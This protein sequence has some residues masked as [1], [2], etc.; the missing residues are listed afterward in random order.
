MI[1]LSPYIVMFFILM[2]ISGCGAD[3]KVIED[4]AFIQTKGYD[5]IAGEDLEDDG[6]EVMYRLTTSAPLVEPDREKPKISRV[7]TAR[8]NKEGIQLNARTT[9]R[10]IVSGQLRLLLYSK[11]VVENGLRPLLDVLE[12]DP[13][14]PARAKLAIVEGEVNPLMEREFDEHPRTTIYLDELLEKEARFNVIPEIKVYQFL[15]DLKDDGKDPTLPMI[16]LEEEGVAVN[17]LAFLKNDVYKTKLELDDSLIY[18]FLEK[19]VDQGDL[20]MSL[21]NPETGKNELVSFTSISTERDISVEK[22]EESFDVNIEV[23][24][25]GTI[26]ENIGDIDI[27]DEEGQKEIEKLIEEYVTTKAEEII[28]FTQ[29][30]SVDPLGIGKKVRNSMSFKEWEELNWREEWP[31]VRVNVEVDIDIRDFGMSVRG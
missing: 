11:K 17:G 31:G 1:K 19:D 29:Q 26:L 18:F 20:N 15:R 22:M 13:Q 23:E 12:R 28:S 21:P 30:S 25:K 3:E 7:T 6:E 5:I 27:S 4:L 16:K 24:M 10:N 2:L 9:E 14:I 8:L